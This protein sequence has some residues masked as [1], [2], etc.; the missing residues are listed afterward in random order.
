MP[1]VLAAAGGQLPTD[2]VIDGV[3]LL[4]FLG[5]ANT[6]AVKQMERPLFW[7]DGAYRAVQDKGWKL[8]SSATPKKDWLFD[9]KT[10]PTEKQNLAA[11]QPEKLAALKARLKSH[12]DPMP[13]PLW[14][15]FIELPI[16]IDKT[17]DQ[18]Q[19]QED[20]FTYWAN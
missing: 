5:K 1:T 18:K 10:D 9:L 7:R 11:T 6:A 12:H 16:S 15:T 17:L 19:S 3:N 4:P 14:P 20:E 13:A 8:I 2:R